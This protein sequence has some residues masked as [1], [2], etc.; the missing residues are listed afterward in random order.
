M[1]REMKAKSA[2]EKAASKKKPSLK[3]VTKTSAMVSPRLSSNH[4]QTLL[5]H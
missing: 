3:E 1:K 4:N 2:S 5:I